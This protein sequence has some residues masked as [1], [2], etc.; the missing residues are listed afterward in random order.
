[1]KLYK[2]LLAT[3]ALAL[4]GITLSSCD[5]DLA[6]PPL[7]VPSSDLKAN[8]TIA[9]FKAKYWSDNDNY[10]T[11]VGLTDEGE[12]IILGGRIIANDEGGNI[13]QNLMLADET[14]AITIATLTSSTD[15]LQHL[16]TKYK[17]GEEMFVKA[18]DLYAGKYAGLF[19]IG[20][21]GDYNGTPQTSKMAAL[22]FL[23]HT[24]LNGLPD[25]SLVQP[26]E[27]TISE[28]NAMTSVADQQKY[29]SQLVRVNSVSWIGGGSQL[30][31]DTNSTT[32]GCDRYLIDADGQRLLVRNSNK[33]DFCDQTL[34]AGHGDV[35]GIL[36]YYT[37]NKNSPFKWQFVFRTPDDC[38]DFQGETYTP[39]SGEAV[40]TSLN[41]TFEG[42]SDISE[43]TNWATVNQMG[44]ATWFTQTYSNNTFA[45]CTGYNKSAGADG[46][47]SWLITPGLDVDNMA[48]KL[49]SFQSMVGYSGNGTLEVFAMNSADPT[50]ATLTKL[51]ANIPAP[52]GSWS[53]WIASGNIDLSTFSGVVYIGFRYQAAVSN[54]NTYTTYRVDNVVAG[55][56]AEEGG[57]TPDPTGKGSAD[58][59][60]SVTDVIAGATGSGV[61]VT[62]YIVGAVNDKSISSAAFAAPFSLNSN[63]LIAA[64]P[65]E[66]NV[67][68]CV[69]VQLA[70]GTDARTALNLV[71]HPDNLGK[72]VSIKG[73]L[74][75]YFGKPGSKGST[76]YAWGAKG[77]ETTTPDPGPTG[78]AQ[79]KK[80][81]SITSGK[82]YLLVADG[83][84]AKLGTGNYGWLYVND[85][86]DT[87]GTITADVA[88]AY[89]FTAVTGG[90]NITMSDG[91]YVYQTGNYDSFNFS[92]TAEDGSLWTVTAQS[93][94]TFKIRNANTSKWIQYQDSYTSY[95]CYDEEKG[96]MP[97]LYEKV[98]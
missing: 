75:A 96:T 51:N 30:W 98:N 37:G 11:R 47:T 26:I 1:M 64:T 70:S 66:T 12:E 67:D 62:G 85:V 71:D 43:L 40:V 45:A 21:A 68:K 63:I 65:G 58:D 24:E 19:Q 95:G 34:P 77:T 17:V 89:T 55:S 23:A 59:P 80:V 81:T 32:S 35:I 91:R 46:Y 49:F 6:T 76:A 7:S 44:N 87:N 27:M 50:T 78:S 10:C 22:D 53:D 79:F 97:A 74:T 13:Y 73:D 18:T 90:Y 57:D 3:M 29:Q 84:M 60:Y 93:D 8:M 38:I 15:G 14:G 92:A 20:A 83:K 88:N 42:L 48:E 54:E 5:E 33:S 9:D 39:S 4:C 25:P 61:W 69:P 86:T 16:Y 31:G 72:Q 41:Q 94:G 36:S 82:Q 2:S 52:K 56:Q 28:I